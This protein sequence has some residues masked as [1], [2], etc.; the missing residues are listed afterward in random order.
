VEG[1]A[2]GT[3]EVYT[4]LGVTLFAKEYVFS[5]GFTGTA[6]GMGFFTG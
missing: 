5:D 2:T 3:G 1:V 4:V 6:L